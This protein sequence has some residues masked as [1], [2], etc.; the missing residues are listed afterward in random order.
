MPLLRASM[1]ELKDPDVITARLTPTSHHPAPGAARHVPLIRE[2]A[3]YQRR[4]GSPEA[5]RIGEYYVDITLPRVMG[6]EINRRF[7]R[8]IVEIDGRRSY[9]VAH[10]ENRE[11]GLDR[12][13]GAQEVTDR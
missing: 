3:K 7:H 10:G 11:D 5:E 12:A 2:T 6:H 8:R 4:V 1:L 9:A 13:S